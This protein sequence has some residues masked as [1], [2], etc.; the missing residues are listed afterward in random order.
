MFPQRGEPRLNGSRNG[1]LNVLSI[2]RARIS[3]IPEIEAMVSDFVKGH[4]AE[5]RSRL[6][7]RVAPV[8]ELG[9]AGWLVLTRASW[10]PV[11]TDGSLGYKPA[12]LIGVT[13]PIPVIIVD[14]LGGFRV[15]GHSAGG[16]QRRWSVSVASLR[17][18]P[19]LR[20]SIIVLFGVA[21][22]VGIPSVGATLP[23]MNRSREAP[24]S[25]DPQRTVTRRLGRVPVR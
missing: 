3:D 7:E 1:G 19:S 22:S 24:C 11:Q 20:L 5:G 21:Y 12:V 23:E 9:F 6:Y 15:R 25:D 14:W 2:R 18:P 8:V 4:P 17:N 16:L 10:I 13:L